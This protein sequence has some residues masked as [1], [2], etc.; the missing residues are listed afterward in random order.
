MCPLRLIPRIF[1]FDGY[2]LRPEL[3]AQRILNKGRIPE[4]ARYVVTNPSSYVFSAITASLD[5]TVEFEPLGNGKEANRVG[6]LRVPMEARFVINDGQHRSAAIK[7]A[8]TENPDLGDETIAV[9]FFIDIGLERCQQMFTDLNRYAIRPS[10]SLNVL[11]DHRDETAL[12]TKRVVAES[13]LFRDLVEKEK[14]SLAPRSRKLFTLS[15]IYVAN[16]AL[17]SN[18]DMGDQTHLAETAIAFW[19]S[20]ADQLPEWRDAQDGRI[21]AG[22]VRRDFIHSHG[23]VLQSLGHLGNILFEQA[24]K[25]WQRRL[26]ALRKLDWSRTNAKT[27]E[28]RAIVGGQVSKSRQNVILTTNVLKQTL[29]LPLSPE[30][31]KAETAFLRSEHG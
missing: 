24:P 17:V 4:M 16:K 18:W 31:Q 13:G 1:E 12:L 23:V 15:G 30:E 5:A 28:G 20:V 25:G 19:E 26:T 22:D 11:Y 2:D 9:V 27:W 29:N 6:L 3:R 14:T 8:L 10:N 7:A 21:T